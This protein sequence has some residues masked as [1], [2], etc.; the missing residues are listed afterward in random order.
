MQSGIQT[1]KRS[2]KDQGSF[3]MR[4]PK[5][6]TARSIWTFSPTCALQLDLSAKIWIKVT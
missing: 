1:D 5:V 4:M 2:K 6:M 3:S